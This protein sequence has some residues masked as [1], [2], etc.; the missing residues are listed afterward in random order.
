MT[1]ILIVSNSGVPDG[2]GRIADN[3]A[4]RLQKRNYQIV[5]ASL[6]Y[7]GLLPP[8]YDGQ[9]LPY[10]VAAL[11]GKPNW[12]ELVAAIINNVNP[13]IVL[14][15]QDAPYLEAVRGLPLDWSR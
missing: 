11:A 13:D 4:L 1:K 7:D 10:W 5:A 3:I 8:Q 9:G 2:F 15:C 14:V 6:A 12:P